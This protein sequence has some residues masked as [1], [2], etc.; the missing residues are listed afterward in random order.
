[1][2]APPGGRWILVAAAVGGGATVALAALGSHAVSLADL[3]AAS[4]WNTAVAL[5]G[6]HALALLAIASLRAN[7]RSRLLDAAALAMAAGSLVFSGSLLLRATGNT[8]LPPG[9]PPVG[10]L[11]LLLG[12]ALLLS[13]GFRRPEA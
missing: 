6:F 8:Y 9:L 2:T 13:A 4:L 3:R 7:R 10:G 1:M 5:L 11:L 12:W